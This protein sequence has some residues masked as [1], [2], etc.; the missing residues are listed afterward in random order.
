MRKL[1]EWELD[2]LKFVEEWLDERNEFF[3]VSSSGSTG[4]PK[5]ISI[6]RSQMIES[7]LATA[8]YLNLK[9][10]Q[11]SLLILPAQFIAGKMMIV[12]ALVLGL[13]FYYLEP[14][15]DIL[16]HI[17]RGYDFC[18]AIPLQVQ[19][20]LNS[21]VPEKLDLLSEVII[22]GAALAN[23][24]IAKLKDFKTHFH[25]TY[26]MTETIT[27]IAMKPLNDSRTSQSYHCLPGISIDQDSRGCLRIYSQR[28]PQ[29]FTVT[30]DRVEL[31]NEKEFILLGRA[32]AVINSGGLKI[33]TE[34]LEE[35]I[36]ENLGLEIMIGYKEDDVLGQKVVLLIEGQAEKFDKQ[37]ILAQ[38]QLFLSK[39][40][41]PKEILF[42]TLLFK[43]PNQKINRAQNQEW[44]SKNC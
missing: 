41:L 26:G 44:I 20:V 28:L 32:D 4:K 17:D 24:D 15:V 33:Q 1:E 39:N 43:T 31:I 22:G 23:K 40:K 10:G 36:K 12:R 19:K 9:E 16:M 35:L 30:N 38:L 29:D 7:A 8:D 3:L 11:S 6:S 42:I 25:A 2:I 18:A 27:H 34:E 13:D 14:K 37:K 21:N 5:I